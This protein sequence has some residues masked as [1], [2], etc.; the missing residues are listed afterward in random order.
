MSDTPTIPPIGARVYVPNER[1]GYKVM[2]RSDR[3]AVCTKPH[4]STV[5]YFILDN[6][7][8]VRGPENLI[9]GLGAETQ[10]QC[11]QMIMRLEVGDTEV[12]HRRRVPWD[13]VRVAL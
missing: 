9:F 8:L 7:E 3:Y 13:V 5:L 11:E 12:S 1:R 2:A 4:F 6:V 10:E